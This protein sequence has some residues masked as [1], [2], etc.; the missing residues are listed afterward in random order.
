MMNDYEKIKKMYE[1]GFRCIRYDD[2]KDGE[3]SIYFKN[4]DNE[5]SLAMRVSNFDE[6]MKIKSFVKDNSIK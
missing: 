4:F 2:T 1:N 5:E 6:K 3:M